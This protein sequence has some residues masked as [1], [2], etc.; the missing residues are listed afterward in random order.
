M[1]FSGR[2]GRVVRIK[3][4]TNGAKYREIL[5]EN[6]PQSAQDIS[7]DVKIGA[8]R[9]FPSNLTELERISSG[10]KMCL[11]SHIISCMDSL[12]AITVLT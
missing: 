9:K 2:T 11:T 7:G 6:L 4:K 10:V 3:G 12:C 5:D 8:Q 1:F